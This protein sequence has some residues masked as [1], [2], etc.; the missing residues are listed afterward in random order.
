M[1]DIHISNSLDSFTSEIDTKCCS[2]CAKTQPITSFLKNASAAPGSKVFALCFPFPEAQARAYKNRKALHQLGPENL[3]IPPET[4]I[5]AY[6]LTTEAAFPARIPIRAPLFEVPLVGLPCD[7]CVPLQYV[8]IDLKYGPLCGSR[9]RIPNDWKRKTLSWGNPTGGLSESAVRCLSFC[10]HI[11][12]ASLPGHDS[13]NTSR[14]NLH[15]RVS[16]RS[17]WATICIQF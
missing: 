4:S 12:P 10:P 5:P 9:T 6:F 11:L 14:P 17:F 7:I 3:L 2:A 1:E 13:S 16:S 8:R 15:G